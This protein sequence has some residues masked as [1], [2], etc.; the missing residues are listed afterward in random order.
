MHGTFTVNAGDVKFMQNFSLGNLEGK[1]KLYRP[2]QMGR[3]YSIKP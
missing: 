2:A 1:E 3:Q